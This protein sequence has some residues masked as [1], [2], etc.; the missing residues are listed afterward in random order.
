MSK[1]NAARKL[2]ASQLNIVGLI[3]YSAVYGFTWYGDYHDMVFTMERTP[4][5]QKGNWLMIA[6]YAVLYLIFSKAFE[7]NQAG[8]YK[9]SDMFLADAWTLLCVNTVTFL[10]I[11]LMAVWPART[12]GANL[13][14]MVWATLADFAIAG[15][16]AAVSQY[17]YRTAFPPRKL[18]LIHGDRPVELLR[19]KLES[20]KDRYHIVKCM[21][22]SEGLERLKQEAVSGYEGVM[23]WEVPDKTRNVLLKYLYSRSIRI[24]FVPKISDVLVKGAGQLHLFDMPIYMLREYA[25]SFGQRVAKRS[26]DIVCALI[27]LVAASPVMAVTALIIK[28]YDKGPVFYRQIRCTQNA[29]K[30]TIL[31]FRSMRVDAEKDGMV[32]MASRHDSRITPIGRF[33]RAVRIDEL[34]QLLNILRG[35]MSFIGPRPERPELI[36]EY[37]REMPEFAFRMKVKAGLA[38]YAQVYGKYN[39]TPYDKLKLDLTYI[40]NYSVWLDI[41]LMLLTLKILLKA[42]STEGVEDSQSQAVN[43]SRE[44]SRADN[45]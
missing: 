6:I 43:R 25:L 40:E 18:L 2:F 35:D 5:W 27:L 3:L 4:F 11:A 45:E 10:Q 42:E 20:R 7:G 21:N 22:V 36:E 15:I 31:K 29:R 12:W 41:R 28:V 13:L 34:P 16:W 33:I 9:A 44:E 30:F 26:I 24:Y 17:I 1:R 37:L 39:T 23:L 32:R 14:P 19:D 38:G 8:F